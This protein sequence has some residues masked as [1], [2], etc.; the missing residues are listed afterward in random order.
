MKFLILWNGLQ[1]DETLILK[2]NQ[3]I[4]DLKDIYVLSNYNHNILKFQCEVGLK[5]YWP[6]IF[7]CTFNQFLSYQSCS[8][9]VCNH[10]LNAMTR[11]FHIFP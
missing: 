4:E 9:F 1:V 8:N 7:K 5:I 2:K 3:V 10:K 11:F 6:F